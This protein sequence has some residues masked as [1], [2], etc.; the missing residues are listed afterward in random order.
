MPQNK[1]LAEP[2][3]HNSLTKE[4]DGQTGYY[5]SSFGLKETYR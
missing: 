2:Q 3:Q 5:H 4:R 1:G